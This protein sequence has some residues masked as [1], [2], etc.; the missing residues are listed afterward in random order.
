MDLTTE[1]LGAHA[2]TCT[3]LVQ[4]SDPYAPVL[5]PLCVE[6]KKRA[7]ATR[8][9]ADWC[10]TMFWARRYSSMPACVRDQRPEL[11]TD[12]T[13]ANLA[14][15]IDDLHRTFEARVRILATPKG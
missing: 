10:L 6:F 4:P 7:E 14:A 3:G 13:L 9:A 11:M 1:Q 15:Q 2:A 5:C 8:E 12:P